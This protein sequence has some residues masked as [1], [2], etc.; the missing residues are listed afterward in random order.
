MEETLILYA[1]MAILGA[2]VIVL[3]CADITDKTGMSYHHTLVGNEG[4]RDAGVQ[5]VRAA[6]QV[7][8]AK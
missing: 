7:K 3:T 2:V 8:K 1:L 4:V 6:A 5:T